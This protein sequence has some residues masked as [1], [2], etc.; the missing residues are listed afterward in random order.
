MRGVKGGTQSGL[1]EEK[2]WKVWKESLCVCVCVVGE[3]N[4]CVCVCWGEGCSPFLFP[5]FR[6]AS[7]YIVQAGAA[8]SRLAS[9]S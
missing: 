1:S 8:L 5:C 6:D 3:E 4:L 9:N 7:G 2:E